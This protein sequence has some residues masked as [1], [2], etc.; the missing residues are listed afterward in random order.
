MCL[1][2]KTYTIFFG[3]GIFTLSQTNTYLFPVAES[4]QYPEEKWNKS[5]GI[6]YF[7]QSFTNF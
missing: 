2:S 5:Q 6:L 7:S 1:S 4:L 3:S